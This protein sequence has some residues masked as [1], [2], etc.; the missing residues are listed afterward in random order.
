MRKPPFRCPHC[1]YNPGEAA[2]A[3]L[4]GSPIRVC[5]KCKQEYVDRR[6]HEIAID[7]IRHEDINITP[8]RYAKVQKNA[9]LSIVVGSGIFILHFMIR[10]GLAWG[11]I[12]VLGVIILVSGI[13][14][15]MGG[16]KR[17]IEKN[18]V[19]L[20]QERKMS[21]LRMKDSHYVQK[22][23]TIGYPMN[24]PAC[25]EEL[26]CY[27]PE[28]PNC[29]CS[30]TPATDVISLA[31]SRIS[32]TLHKAIIVTLGVV[33]VVFILLTGCS[34]IGGN[35]EYTLKDNQMKY[36]GTISSLGNQQHAALRSFLNEGEVDNREIDEICCTDY[37][38][39][40]ADGMVDILEDNQTVYKKGLIEES[41][42]FDTYDRFVDAEFCITDLETDHKYYFC[43]WKD[44]LDWIEDGR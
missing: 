17:S 5:A 3:Y 33:L 15:L 36:N 6:Y 11:L 26:R 40:R 8:E 2:D 21:V 30:I 7:G 42:E 22:L 16:I 20:E 9:I 34:M 19:V 44:V 25:N 41:V 39:E 13:D 4:Y 23:R 27:Q 14:T 43:Y 1:G 37:T 35:G 24:C 28:C 29:G 38:I 12:A 31:P 18:R 10:L 32:P